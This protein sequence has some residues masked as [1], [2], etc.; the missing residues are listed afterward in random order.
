MTRLV[1]T[2]SFTGDMSKQLDVRV[3]GREQQS[4]GHFLDGVV[5]MGF[6]Q[7]RQ[8]QDELRIVLADIYLQLIQDGK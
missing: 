3:R 2:R 8:G 5:G 7:L 4:S 6:V 1:F